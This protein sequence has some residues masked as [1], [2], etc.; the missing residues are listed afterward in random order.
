MGTFDLETLI[1]RY[2]VAE[3]L[4]KVVK[5]HRKALSLLDIKHFSCLSAPKY[6]QEFLNIQLMTPKS[7]FQ[8]SSHSFEFLLIQFLNYDFSVSNFAAGILFAAMEHYREQ[9][10]SFLCTDRETGLDRLK[11]ID[12]LNF[13]FFMLKTS[14]NT[15]SS[16]LTYNTS[17]QEAQ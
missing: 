14:S 10:M 5:N 4:V 3:F 17:N 1:E 16:L 12:V 15:I 8:L 7:V 13:T 6:L 9:P 11:A 2:R